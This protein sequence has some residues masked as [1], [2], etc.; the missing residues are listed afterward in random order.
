[1]YSELKQKLD[2]GKSKIIHLPT[3]ILASILALFSIIFLKIFYDF[4]LHG[5]FYEQIITLLLL[6][7]MITTEII[8]IYTYRAKNSLLISLI[9]LETALVSFFL[10]LFREIWFVVFIGSIAS[11]ITIIYGYK[12]KNYR[13]KPSFNSKKAKVL[14]L[15][16]ILTIGIHPIASLTLKQTKIKIKTQ[17]KKITPRFYLR[18]DNYETFTHY[19]EN[20]LSQ[21]VLDNLKNYNGELFLAITRGDLK[22]NSKAVKTAKKL[23]QNNVTCH[24]WLLEKQEHGY[25]ANDLN[26]EHFEN[27]VEEFLI[28]E[29]KEN[30][31]FDI[32]QLD[33]EILIEGGPEQF[34][35]NNES[36]GVLDYF[37]KLKTYYRGGP[38]NEVA[39]KYSSLVS[40][41]NQ[42]HKSSVAAYPIVL[43]DVFDDDTA[44]QDSFAISTYPP[45][46]WDEIEPMVYRVG[47][48]RILKRDLDSYLV[49]SYSYSWKSKF[50]KKASIAIARPDELG[51]KDPDEMVKDSLI[52]ESLGFKNVSIFSIGLFLETHGENEFASF[53]K[54]VQG[55]SEKDVLEISYKPLVSY[56][57]ILVSFIDR[58]L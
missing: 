13:F 31:D 41:I 8:G 25:W 3:I 26:Y 28:W 56:S 32:I 43:E 9:F 5:L 30:L 52:L 18:A 23:N 36:P 51:Y 14:L 47:F 6:T 40:R 49:Y 39:D 27:M 42:N 45:K 4:T 7:S 21:N 34:F 37:S 53:L 44:L 48:H 50:P 57:R 55:N 1:M 22:E 54:S 24:A 15:I 12:K 10:G 17:D 38:R 29:N 11:I 35:D 46:N 19:T 2:H 20:T 58:L 33:S 16:L